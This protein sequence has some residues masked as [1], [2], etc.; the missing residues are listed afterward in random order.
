MIFSMTLAFIC[1]S[2]LS[3]FIR[4]VTRQSVFSERNDKVPLLG[5]PEADQGQARSCRG[6]GT[7]LCVCVGAGGGRRREGHLWTLTAPVA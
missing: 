7:V 4:A 3:T 6:C 1:P 2:S 5:S